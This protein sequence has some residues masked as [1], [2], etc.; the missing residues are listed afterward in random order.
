LS[1]YLDINVVIGLLTDDP[2]NSRATAMLRSNS[3]P[4]LISDFG[5]AEYSAVVGRRVR[6]GMITR[7][8]GLDALAI[9]DQWSVRNVGRVEIEPAD[10]AAAGTYLRRFD[11]SLRTPDAIHIAI[12]RRVGAM[13]A[14]FDQRMAMAARSLDL[15]VT[16]A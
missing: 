14:T 6:M 12:T 2:L 5:A 15:V 10:V 13:L 11:L 9:F 4:L 7:Q 1:L 16:N 3:E 8:H